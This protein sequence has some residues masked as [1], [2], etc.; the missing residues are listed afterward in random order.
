MAINL[1]KGATISLAKETPGLSKVVLGAGWGKKTTKGFFGGRKETA[2]DLDASCLIFDENRSLIDAVWFQQ[3]SS[4][5]GAIKHTGDDLT[6]GGGANDPNEEIVVQL[7]KVD[8]RVKSLVFTIN[9][10]S[11][12]SFEGIPNAFCVLK[13]AENSSEIARFDLSVEGR[14]YTGLVIA[15]L[16][17][18]NGEW[19]FKALGE[20]GEGRTFDKLLPNI[21]PQI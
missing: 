21:L 6:G 2:I 13:N 14:S 18:H 7:D 8:P 17:R 20:W 3:L 10:F 5:D 19:K 15:K 1:Q 16:Y 9:S 12:D 11:N 4:N